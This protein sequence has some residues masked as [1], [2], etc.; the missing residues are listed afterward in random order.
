MKNSK[1]KLLA[2]HPYL[3]RCYRF[4]FLIIRSIVIGFAIKVSHFCAP[5]IK[6]G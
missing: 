5:T 2:N 4:K 1:A 3:Y 6:P